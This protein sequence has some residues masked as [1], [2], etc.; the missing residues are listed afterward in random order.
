MNV[1]INSVNQAFAD[2]NDFFGGAICLSTT[3]AQARMRLRGPDFLLFSTLMVPTLG[4]VGGMGRKW[5]LPRCHS[6]TNVTNDCGDRYNAKKELYEQV[7]ER[8]ITCF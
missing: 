4:K 3:A 8:E 7:L 6:R 5:T 1:L 2:R